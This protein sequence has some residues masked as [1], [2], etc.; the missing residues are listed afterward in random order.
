MPRLIS[1]NTTDAINLLD[2]LWADVLSEGDDESLIDEKIDKLINSNR[3]A[4]RYCLPIQ[5]LGKLTDHQVDALRMQKGSD[6]DD[7]TAWEPREFAK[8]VIV[9]WVTENDNVLGT[10]KDP[11][12]GNP[13]RIPRL[14]QNP[15]G[16]KSSDLPLWQQVYEVIND[17]Q[18]RDDPNYTRSR[19]RQVLR[20]IK[21]KLRASQFD[22]VIPE[23]VSLDQVER[24]IDKFLSE[25]SGGDRGL[26][27]AAA[28]FATIG[29]LLGIYSDVVR[30]AINA[31]DASTG[32]TADIECFK[33]NNLKLAVEVKERNL[34]LIDVKDGITKA[35]KKGVTEL[36]FNVSNTDSSE[37]ATIEELMAKTWASGTNLYRV[38]IKDLIH[39]GLSITGEQGR[40][41]F[42]IK[43]GE[44][45]NRFNTQPANRLKW[46]QLLDAV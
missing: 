46:K 38:S 9:P 8:K 1:P 19:F 20:S 30:H 27:V 6:K 4:I 2:G 26:S 23:R 25:G 22:F 40:R 33:G 29:E 17:V 10:S 28:W 43:V 21:K 15:K 36:L 37:A 34:T 12:V 3:V 39:V 35:R 41:T 13:A 44:Q 18:D 32:A 5:L 45:L 31:S 7:P 42:L 11:Y 14:S 16:I 24:I